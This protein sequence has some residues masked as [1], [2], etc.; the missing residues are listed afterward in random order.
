M[1]EDF[2]NDTV[3]ALTKPGGHEG[4]SDKPYQDTKGVWTIGHGLT[5]LTEEESKT[6]VASRIA[7][8]CMNDCKRVF[9][10][11][12][13]LTAK[14][15]S[16]VLNMM[17]NLGPSGLAGFVKMIA[18]IEAGDY[19]RASEEMIDSKWSAQVGGRARQLSGQM[20]KG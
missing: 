13:S 11:F 16:V 12:D 19:D 17:Y 1:S 7:G 4:F 6:I 15:K 20:R 2:I 8:Q 3:H 9:S 5:Y 14:R 10:T 18:A